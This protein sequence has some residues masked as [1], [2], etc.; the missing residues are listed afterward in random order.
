MVWIAVSKMKENGKEME[1][2]AYNLNEVHSIYKP[3]PALSV[4][5]THCK[6]MA[7]VAVDPSNGT[8]KVVVCLQLMFLI[9][10]SNANEGLKTKHD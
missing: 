1:E 8:G 7:V 5:A 4:V 2:W 10:C 3:V 9:R 6:E